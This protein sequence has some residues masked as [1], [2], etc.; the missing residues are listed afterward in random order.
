MKKP[1]P[2]DVVLGV[3]ALFCL[4]A[5]V[6][7]SIPGI[8]HYPDK[9]LGELL[10]ATVPRL[11]VSAILVILLV[12]S[13]YAGTLKPKL[14]SFPFALL[15]SIPCLLVAIVN[16][17]F[18]ALITGAAKIERVD[19]LW[20]FLLKCL[21]IALMEELFFRAL[22]VPFFRKLTANRGHG[23]LLCVLLSSA[24]FSLMHLANLFFGAELSDTM[25]QIGYTF[26]IGCMLAVTL[27][28]T[29]NVWI[30]VLVHFLFDVGG[31]IVTDLGSGPFQDLTFWILTAVIGVLCAVH[32]IVTLCFMMRKRKS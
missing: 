28:Q 21:S 27:L 19:L 14:R 23:T 4:A 2:I 6:V 16:F 20:L 32:I 5:C 8:I 24:A 29:K 11:T 1:K 7:F 9:T 12:R 17:P 18:T 26:L 22:L 30:C 10:S 3:L 25:L 15:W 31:T 13:E